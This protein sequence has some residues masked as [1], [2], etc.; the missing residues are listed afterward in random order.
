MIKLY[1]HNKG[2]DLDIK[3]MLIL[4]IDVKTMWE[5]IKENYPE[6]FVTRAQGKYT[7]IIDNVVIKYFDYKPITLDELGEMIE[8][9]RTIKNG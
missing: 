8:S 5:Y 9:R 2:E 7:H 1:I 4:D 6:S 3:Q